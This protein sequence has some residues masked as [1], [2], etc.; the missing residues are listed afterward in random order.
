M[1]VEVFAKG[2]PVSLHLGE[3]NMLI[4]EPAIGERL[5]QLAPN[6]IERFPVT[7]GENSDGYEIINVIQLKRCIDDELSGAVWEPDGRES[8][9][10][11][12]YQRFE[13]GLHIDPSLTDGA[14]IF[15]LTGTPTDIFIT[16]P[17]K[18]ALEKFPNLGVMFREVATTPPK[19]QGRYGPDSW[20]RS[21]STSPDDFAPAGKKKQIDKQKP[22]AEKKPAK[23][24][25]K[26]A[27]K[28][29]A[30]AHA[31][32][33]Y[34][35]QPT[36]KQFAS[37]YQELATWMT[38]LE[39]PATK[40]ITTDHAGKSRAASYKRRDADLAE[41]GFDDI[42]RF[43]LI[44]LTKKGA[45][46]GTKKKEPATLDWSVCAT[47]ARGEVPYF[48][49]EMRS[50]VLEL[51]DERLHAL[52]QQAV[53]LLK[54]LYGI[55]YSARFDHGPVHFAAGSLRDDPVTVGEPYELEEALSSWRIGDNG[56]NDSL[57]K[58]GLIRGVYPLNFLNE[59]QL[60][61]TLTGKAGKEA[62]LQKWIKAD[63]TRG[64]LSECGKL[65]LW[66]V[67]PDEVETL[68]EELAETDIVLDWMS[69]LGE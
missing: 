12:S 10:G 16:E 33:F 39:H 41:T 19:K 37:F 36:E 54:P 3:R 11:R 50:R 59:K 63:P 43:C 68:R 5:Q 53:K 22:V 14:Q 23:A 31:L 60:T 56:F 44:A 2:K 20:H 65:T 26:P 46:K 28:K 58:S 24:G 69:G 29:N 21:K 48:V 47:V 57:Y 9:D 15:R 67:E 51:D 55:G 42:D 64:E 32:L 17:I 13:E 1:K 52:C 30:T 38:D 6:D 45:K 35:I 34:G 61:H 66:T 49:L 25:K 40:T 4:A 7:V 27:K 62:T 18:L 8:L